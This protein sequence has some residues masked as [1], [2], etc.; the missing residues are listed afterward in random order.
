MDADPW[1]W[2]VAEVQ[3]FFRQDAVDCLSDRPTAQLPPLDTFLQSLADSE[4][5]GPS[6]IDDVDAPALRD[7]FGI[8]SFRVRGT[9]LHCIRKLKE[10]SK[11]HRSPNGGLP[12]TPASLSFVPQLTSVPDTPTNADVLPSTEINDN[13][14]PGEVQVQDAHGRKRRKLDIFKTQRDL[15][16]ARSDDTGDIPDTAIS[17]DELFYGHTELGNEIGTLLSAGNI[18]IEDG[19]TE[20]ADDNFQFHSQ[21]QIPMRAEFV[22]ARM[23]YFLMNAEAVDLRRHDRPATGILPY[24]DRMQGKERSATVVQIGKD[25]G[26]YV[27]IREQATLLESGYEHKEY[28][29]NA[30]G[31]SSYLLSKYKHKQD[32]LDDGL[33]MFDGSEDGDTTSDSGTSE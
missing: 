7:D 6:L 12:E 17:L 20:T 19:D 31:D 14:R 25:G 16:V 29:Q 4:V 33:P 8:S 15:Q 21:S 30:T 24:S 2:T 1:N 10:R 32:D 26:E 28:Q 27:A 22:N 11:F 3:Q 18:L 13:I 9:I 5:D 23:C